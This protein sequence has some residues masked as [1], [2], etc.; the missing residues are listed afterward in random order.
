[1]TAAD[2]PITSVLTSGVFTGWEAEIT[3]TVPEEEDMLYGRFSFT[4]GSSGQL[5]YITL[6]GPSGEHVASQTFGSF[7]VENPLP[8]QYRMTYD[9]WGVSSTEY[10]IGTGPHFFTP[11]KLH[12]YHVVCRTWD[13]TFMLFVGTL[14]EYSGTEE[15]I[16]D[17][18]LSNGGDFL[19]IKEP[20]Y[21]I[22][23]KPIIK[24]YSQQDLTADLSLTFPGI[25]T[26]A[27]PA[28]ETKPAGAATVLSWHRIPVHPQRPA[29]ILYEGKFHQPLRLLEYAIAPDRVQVRNVSQLPVEDLHLVHYRSAADVQIVRVGDLN[30][31]EQSSGL[32]GHSRTR[33]EAIS[34]LED[35]IQQGG[36]RHGLYQQEM[37]AFTD[38]YHWVE[39][40]LNE[41]YH[42]G[43]W[44]ALYLLATPAYDQLIGMTC[45]PATFARVRT[46]WIL[47]KEIPA[48]LPLHDRP[49]AAQQRALPSPHAAEPTNP[50]Y[51]EYGVIEQPYC[52]T[53]H[54]Q[55]ENS[56]YFGW[57]FYDASIILDP[58]DNIG[59]WSC[60]I[61]QAWGDH[62]AVD[63]LSQDVAQVACCGASPIGAGLGERILRADAD[64]YSEDGQF[65]PGSRPTVVAGKAIGNGNVI[66]VHDLDILR[67]Q[68]DNIQL[69]KNIV[70]WLVA[71]GTGIAEDSP[72]EA[73]PQVT[74]LSANHP[75]PFNPTTS[76]QYGLPAATMV[77]LSI[78]DLAGRL[79]RTLVAERQDAGYHT[80]RW[81]G[82][83]PA[84]R[85]VASGPYLY[86]LRAGSFTQCRRMLL[87]K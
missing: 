61:L 82:T 44:L 21:I 7:H 58:T 48:G 85:A 86:R 47:E 69:L 51:H 36:L 4:G 29:E 72:P 41:A 68:L 64:A 49:T 76:I 2:F 22:A 67:D 81:D 78:F 75:N 83:D 9:S 3:F 38:R 45:D 43:G 80:V 50:V 54:A 56:F 26:Y 19:F 55:K 24:I 15:A 30:P 53:D 5:P 28:C 84:G 52:I 1:L 17:S 25:L 46:M 37:S 16:L 27:R 77:E 31:A 33:A 13:N 87:L 10:E 14:P 6:Y 8:G 57:E 65:L 59:D 79:V 34:Y 74:T 60:P 39:R 73:I 40:W 62:P 23:L 20:L 42:N 66:A 18:Y 35:L 12:Q 63:F 11:Y 71:E 32:C 70:V